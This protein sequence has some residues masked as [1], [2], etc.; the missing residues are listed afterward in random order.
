[1]KICI[2]NT[3]FPPDGYGGAERSVAVLAKGLVCHGHSVSVVCTASQTFSRVN[4]DG[5]DVYGFSKL[6]IFWLGNGSRSRLL[7]FIW[8]FFDIFNLVAFVRIFILLKKLSPDVVHTNNLTGFSTSVFLAA[9][10]LKIPIVHTLRDYYLGC[11]T[12]NA[13]N[14]GKFGSRYKFP[15]RVLSQLVGVVVGCSRYILEWHVDRQY[16]RSSD[17]QVV[18]N[19]YQ[20][21]ATS[22]VNREKLEQLTFGYIGAITKDKGVELL[23]SQFKKFQKLR[24]GK[25]V[26]AGHGSQEYVEKLK[27]EY[28]E[29]NIE[30]IGY[31]TPEH[32]YQQIDWN[33]IP[34]LWEEPLARVCFEPKFFSIPVISSCR[35]GNPEAINEKKDGFI[36]DPNVK[37]G[38]LA[39][40]L[41]AEAA[42]YKIFSQ[43]S[44]YD[45]KRFSVDRLVKEYEIIYQS[46]Q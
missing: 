46:L 33:V 36:F 17:K 15:S 26:I 1:M 3:F 2:L 43:N 24:N 34:S 10:F 11:L 37:D 8:H 45:R 35:G 29:C 7:K 42:D 41:N 9:R 39:Q 38:L 40:L 25:L 44:R 6:N 28:K 12:S 14:S 20:R 5:V 4:K 16:F 22:C 27:S 23:C 18:F 19:A 21:D 32:F 31:S 13:K 30:F